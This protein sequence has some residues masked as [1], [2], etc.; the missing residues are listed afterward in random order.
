MVCIVGN[1]AAGFWITQDVLLLTIQRVK[2]NSFLWRII[3][4]KDISDFFFF[5]FGRK[6]ICGYRNT[7]QSVPLHQI[8]RIICIRS[9]S[10][11]GLQTMLRFAMICFTSTHLIFLFCESRKKRQFRYLSCPN[12]DWVFNWTWEERCHPKS[13]F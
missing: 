11:A 1:T 10:T 3:T 4:H 12:T 8:Y 9:C 5:F 13:S 7:G 2:R 6:T